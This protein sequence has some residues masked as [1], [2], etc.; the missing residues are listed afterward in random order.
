MLDAA[1][2]DMIYPGTIGRVTI[3]AMEYDTGAYEDV[4]WGSGVLGKDIS[5]L[6]SVLWSETAPPTAA[7]ESFSKM[8][9]AFELAQNY[10]NPFNPSTTLSFTLPQPETVTLTVYNTRGEKVATLIE[11]ETK[12]AGHHSVTFDAT[13][14]SSGLYF[15]H[16]QVGEQQMTRTMSLIK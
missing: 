12:T 11:H 3:M 14:L 10:P 5:R 6:A 8:P 4:N 15:Y 13:Q 16:L 7:V 2:L 1:W 9:T